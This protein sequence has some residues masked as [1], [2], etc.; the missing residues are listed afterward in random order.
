MSIQKNTSRPNLPWIVRWVEGGKHRSKSFKSK[1]LATAF[2]NQRR[3]DLSKGIY[4]SMDEQKVLFAEYAQRYMKIGN[5]GQ[6][7]L[8]RDEGI[9]RK[10]VYPSLGQMKIHTIRRSDIQALVDK[11]VANGLKRR[12]I[13]RHVA[14]LSAIFRLAEA[15]GV[16]AKNPVIKISRPP[17]EPPHR[18]VL[19]SEEIQRL[20]GELPTEYRAVVYVALETGMRWSELQRLNIEDF[21]TFGQRLVIKK[22]KTAAG[23]RTIPISETAISLINDLL[24]SS[25]RTGADS[26]EPLFISHSVERST[27]RLAGSRLN[28]SNFRS[29]I[30]KPAAENA[31]IPELAFHDLR[32]TS[33]TL[34]VSQG[35]S[36]KVTQ[37]RLGHADIRTTMNMY[38]QGTNQD[39][40]VALKGL[41]ATLT[42]TETPSD[43]LKDA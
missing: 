16:I 31:G 2:D 24:K 34:L 35:T 37:E 18:R 22:S 15:D 42:A 25:W 12:T 29:R 19:D 10:H 33:A 28:Y 41:Q 5:R 43:I 17:S 38:A 1:V 32:R 23:V 21:N 4:I 14:V 39:H 20:L 30:F 8:T 27:G 6:S 7:T 9:L 3:H 40:R 26:S 13:D 11:W 36:P